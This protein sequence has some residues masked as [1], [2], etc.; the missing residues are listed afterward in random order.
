[1]DLQREG[2]DEVLSK[3]ESSDLFST[4]WPDQASAKLLI[5]LSYWKPFDL[6]TKW[7][8]VIGSSRP[9]VM[10]ALPAFPHSLPFSYTDILLVPQTCCSPPCHRIFPSAGMVSP[11]GTLSDQTLNIISLAPMSNPDLFWVV[12]ILFLHS[13]SQFVTMGF[14]VFS[15]ADAPE[16]SSYFD[17]CQVPIPIFH[18]VLG[19]EGEKDPFF[20]FR[21]HYLPEV[22]WL[23]GQLVGFL[24]QCWQF[25]RPFCKCPVVPSS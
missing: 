24:R 3:K 7:T 1:M 16:R 6:G 8:I 11:P 22:M 17:D 19:S 9:N 25:I 20:H 4:L 13:T 18:S 15:K 10:W 23:V 5:S 21:K 14:Y 12:T 2:H